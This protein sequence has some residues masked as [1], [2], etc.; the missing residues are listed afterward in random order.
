MYKAN[1]NN[2]QIVEAIAV[3]RHTGVQVAVRLY[4]L[5]F[6]NRHNH[7]IMQG[8]IFMERSCATTNPPFRGGCMSIITGANMKLR[9]TKT[10]SKGLD[11]SVL[12]THHWS[13][14]T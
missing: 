1:T 13:Y 12:I 5:Q 4:M 14:Y 10:F 3:S 7:H 6:R 11:K 9:E 8:R 2:K